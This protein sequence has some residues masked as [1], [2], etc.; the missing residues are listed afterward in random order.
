MTTK[1]SIYRVWKV[2]VLFLGIL[3]M[4]PLLSSCTKNENEEV[5][6]LIG[7]A[8]ADLSEDW[9]VALEQEIHNQVD[10][11]DTVELI[12][13]NANGSTYKQMKDLQTLIDYG[14]DLIIV[15]PNDN[16]VMKREISKAHERVPIIVMN[17]K[18]QDSEYDM[19]IGPD[20]N[21]I[22]RMMGLEVV[23]Y[24]GGNMLRVL[25]IKGPSNDVSVENMTKGFHEI[26]GTVENIHIYG[27]FAAD[28][29]E[30]DAYNWYLKYHN[31]YPNGDI[32]VSHNIDMAKGIR[33]AASF[34]GDA[35]MPLIANDAI[36]SNDVDIESIFENGVSRIVKWQL[37]GV[38]AVDYAVEI[39][40][41]NDNIPQAVI[42]N[43]YILSRDT[44]EDFLRD[45][46]TV[47]SD[48]INSIALIQSGLGTWDMLQLESIEMAAQSNNIT[49]H[50]IFIN[51]DETIK[52]K[53]KE[54]IQGI[55]EVMSRGIDAIILSPIVSDG[56]Q[57]VI[58]DV[59][60]EDVATIIINNPIDNSENKNTL[61]LG[62]DGVS[63]GELMGRWLV[64]N[65]Y[66]EK[67]IHLVVAGGNVSNLAHR[68]RMLGIESVIDDYSRIIRVNDWTIDGV[69]ADKLTHLFDSSSD[70]IKV[71]LS[72]DENLIGESI[73]MISDSN[74]TLGTDIRLI[75]FGDVDSFQ[76]ELVKK[77]IDCLISR[78]PDTGTLIFESLQKMLSNPYYPKAI[79]N[80]NDVV[81]Y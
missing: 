30:V 41:G 24:S 60:E 49:V 4:I 55:Y 66:G 71:V 54:Q 70:T 18:I 20:F 68:N 78:S 5:K 75:G 36:R 26:I 48:E 59:L 47:K 13:T 17:R 51:P 28:W 15:T 46:K 38:E 31:Q 9:Q 11:Y 61:F 64:E 33:E 37:G 35:S 74:D 63:E 3:L 44:I 29:K 58:E 69:T 80:S 79:L 72:L 39:L 25:E 32:V 23:D 76:R 73:E 22:G 65:L 7:M 27:E 16:I 42:L 8:H 62:Y 6:Y 53:Q 10:L 45:R 43:N 19:F 1:V 67:D 50:K 81:S 77:Q 2:G 34:V 12:T 14:V 40:N 52:E 56:W 57:E 21:E